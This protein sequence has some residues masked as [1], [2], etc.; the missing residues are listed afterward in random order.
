[1]KKNR[2]IIFC[3]VFLAMFL[4]MTLILI[5]YNSFIRTD[6]V[7]QNTWVED[8]LK[9]LD[10]YTDYFKDNHTTAQIVTDD[11]KDYLKLK[12]DSGIEAVYGTD[13]IRISTQIKWKYYSNEY[14]VNVE[15]YD[16]DRIEN[17]AQVSTSY[18][19]GFGTTV[20][21]YLPDFYEIKPDWGDYLQADLDVKK[22][23]SKEKLQEF[24]MKAEQMKEMVNNEYLNRRKSS[25]FKESIN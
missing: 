20:C 21:Y 11:G 3:F 2:T 9:N 19:G 4:M 16:I 18:D 12:F 1:M 17:T 13:L 14:L 23:V 6:S 7:H 8:V 15:I 24:Y 10:Y 25:E 22:I 5:K